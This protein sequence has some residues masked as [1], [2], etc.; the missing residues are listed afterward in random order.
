[1]TP[2]NGAQRKDFRYDH[3]PIAGDKNNRQNSDRMYL[4][5]KPFPAKLTGTDLLGQKLGH[6]RTR[7][8]L[9]DK[10]LKKLEIR[11][12]IARISASGQRKIERYRASPSSLR[13][14]LPTAT[15]AISTSI[16]EVAELVIG[17]R[18]SP[19]FERQCDL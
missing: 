1:M 5:S 2:K 13:A 14:S 4:P 12:G 11:G 8:E 15:A 18:S 3:P 17:R 16:S 7:A 10:H 6:P 9:F 19:L